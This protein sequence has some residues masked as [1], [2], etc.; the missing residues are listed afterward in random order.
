MNRKSRLRKPSLA[1]MQIAFAG[2][3][4]LPEG[5]FGALKGRAFGETMILGDDHIA[6][7]IRMI[8]KNV[9]GAADAKLH[10]IPPPPRHGA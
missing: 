6:N 7:E 3:Q 2:Q 5:Y 1:A 10:D 8:E 4:S 9:V